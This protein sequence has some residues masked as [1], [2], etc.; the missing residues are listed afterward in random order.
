MMPGEHRKALIKLLRRASGRYS[1]REV[2]R[3]FVTMAAIAVANAVDTRNREAR[4]AEYMRIVARY[5]REEMA[6]FPEMLAMTVEA[7]ETE[8]RDFLG[9]AF[10]EL[11]LGN[12]ERGQFF[13][14]SD[15]CRLIAGLT[16]GSQ[17]QLSEIIARRGYASVHEPA[18]GSG[19]MLIAFSVELA[20]RGV[21]RS[22]QLHVHAIDVDRQAAL[23]CYLQLSLLGIPAEIIVG[24]AL[25]L[26]CEERWFTPAHI[27]GGWQSRISF[28]APTESETSA[29]Q[30]ALF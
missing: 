23:M 27:L 1:K 24:N 2:F 8:P 15:I 22:H 21:S 3:D 7:L 11:E 25:T 10:G 19:A 5:G 13:T 14:P 20:E 18:C 16:I 9:E 30:L 17:E 6:L 12:S 4:E 26:E 28:Q 29:P